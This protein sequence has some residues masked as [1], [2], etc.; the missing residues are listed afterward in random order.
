VQVGLCANSGHL[1]P[2]TVRPGS[3]MSG[4]S[5]TAKAK[6]GPGAQEK[7]NKIGQVD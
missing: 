4:R 7:Q 1:L 6:L 2:D 3:A 5:S